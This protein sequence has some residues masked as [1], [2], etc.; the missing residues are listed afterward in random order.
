MNDLNEDFQN[1]DK[2]KVGVNEETWNEKSVKNLN[3][4]LK[5]SNIKYRILNI[6]YIIVISVIL[7]ILTSSFIYFS[8]NKYFSPIIIDNS[9]CIN[10]CPEIPACPTNNCNC[11]SQNVSVYFTMPSQ[12]NISTYNITNG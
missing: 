9:T 5:I 10:S 2:T 4:I 8:Y 12:L 3:K 1:K 6:N 7:L 11:P